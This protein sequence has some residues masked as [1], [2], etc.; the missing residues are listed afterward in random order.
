[1]KFTQSDIR[2]YAGQNPHLKEPYD[3][4]DIRKTILRCARQ[5][6]LGFEQRCDEP[7]CTLPLRGALDGAPDSQHQVGIVLVSILVCYLRSF[8]VTC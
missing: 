2:M 6:V 3:N 7:A 4:L 1:M 5:K 8:D